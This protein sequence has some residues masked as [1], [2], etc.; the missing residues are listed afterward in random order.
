MSDIFEII[1]NE[2]VFELQFINQDTEVVIVNDNLE[3]NIIEDLTEIVFN[4]ESIEVL[5]IAEQGPPGIMGIAIGPN[6][7]INPEIG[8]LWLDTN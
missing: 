5:T 8:S 7:P 3:I 2:D 1:I 6:A 4:N